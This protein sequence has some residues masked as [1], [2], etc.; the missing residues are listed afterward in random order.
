MQNKDN[1]ITETEIPGLLVI[2]LTVHKDDRGWFKENWQREKMVG[3]GL[4]DFRPVQNNTSYNA[5]RGATRGL[6]AEP[7]DKFVSVAS[8]KV[9]GAWVDL[10]EGDSFG[11]TFSIEITP[12]RAVFVPKGVANGYQ[13]LVSDTSY[14]YLVNAH[15]HAGAKYV[16]VN[17]ADKSLGI[18]WPIALSKAILSD[19][20]KVNPM[21]K[22]VKPIGAPGIFITGGN[23]QLGLALRE[24]YP[25][26]KWTDCE[27]LDITDRNAVRNY[28]WDDVGVLINAAA[29]TNVDGAETEE[30]RRACW[31]VNATG[32]ANL[33]AICAE[34]NIT[35]VHISSDYVF[36]G[37]KPNHSE[38][39]Q[40]SPLS[41][42]GATKA[43]GDLLVTTVPKHYILRTSWVIGDGKNFVRTMME[44][45]KK[46]IS[47]NVVDDQKGR[48]TFTSELV[49][50]IDFLLNNNAAYG[51]YNVSDSGG[52]ASWAEITEEIF[53][54]CGYSG[55][56]V[57][58]ISTEEYFVGKTNIAP[59]PKNSDLDLS[60]LSALGFEFDDWRVELKKYI[61]KELD[62]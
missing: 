38:D 46:G 15:W 49:Q 30:G 25:E 56:R 28:N 13:T 42:Y 3:A 19:K 52:V 58:K 34:K 61:K 31:R 36:D 26:A 27:E 24:K 44:L 48:L 45:G 32:V 7:W 55:L 5:E 53:A 43:V 54:E 62:K 4:P 23:G 12:E 20:D 6:H 1:K 35:L 47:P 40:F 22:D 59:R 17:L 51:T 60:K 33:A 2:D 50:A 41:T 9:F 8:G 57:G 18:K 39:E 11:K 29:Y 14:T 16:A 10:R 37:D 21:L